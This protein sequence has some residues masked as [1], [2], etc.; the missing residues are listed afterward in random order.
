MRKTIPTASDAAKRSCINLFQNSEH[1][2]TVNKVIEGAIAEG[3]TKAGVLF[4]PTVSDRIVRG[5]VYDLMAN[6]YDVEVIAAL[7]IGTQV[8]ACWQ[9]VQ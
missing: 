8:N 9:G 1:F 7:G 2:E 4:A 5:C 3:G 6:G